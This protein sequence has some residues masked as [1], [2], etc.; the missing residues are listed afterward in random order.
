MGDYPTEAPR[1]R[2]LA[3]QRKKKRARKAAPCDIPQSPGAAPEHE[4]E[5]D[6]DDEADSTRC[7]LGSN[8]FDETDTIKRLHGKPFHPGNCWNVVRSHRRIASRS[9]AAVK[10]SDAE[11]LRLLEEV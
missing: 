11:L 4:E 6:D 8:T 3:G 1:S 2:P 10:A 7:F 9:A 5:E